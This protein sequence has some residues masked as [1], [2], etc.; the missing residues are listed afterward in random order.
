MKNLKKNNFK[1]VI[2][3]EKSPNGKRNR[4]TKSGFKNRTEAT[5]AAKAKEREL[6]KGELENKDENMLYK[7]FLEFWIEQETQL[8]KVKN[9]TLHNYKKQINNHLKPTLGNYK[10][11]ALNYIILQDFLNQLSKK[12]YKQT[13]ISNIKGTLSKSLKFAYVKLRYIDSD[14]TIGLDIPKA[15]FRTS[16]GKKLSTQQKNTVIPKQNIDMLLERF[17]EGNPAHLPIQLGYRCGLRDGEAYAL[18][19]TDINFEEKTI[20]INKQLQYDEENKFWYL[21][22]PKYNSYR[23][24]GMDKKL[25][26]LLK[27]EK[28]RQEVWKSKHKHYTKPL[29]NEERIINYIDGKTVD[30][31]I[32]KPNGN[33]ITPNA[34]MHIASVAHHELK[35]PY[36][37]HS[38][39]HTHATY[40]A[41][42][43]TDPLY[44]KE[45][46][47]HKNYTVTM[48]Y[49]IHPTDEFRKSGQEHLENIMSD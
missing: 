1:Y 37:Y 31:I 20:D 4:K 29:V 34:R 16:K 2:E 33:F 9:T 36:T 47:G 35:I 42:K 41:T 15:N 3:L 6:I 25:A 46:L 12:G 44:T 5:K 22:P 10:I 45:R 13:T 27:R 17:P 7:D 24:I 48:K 30:F 14:P 26:N 21:A 11:K 18:T 8:G 19:W 38:L 23:V 49:Y 39:R 32:R 40:L 28:E 43:Q